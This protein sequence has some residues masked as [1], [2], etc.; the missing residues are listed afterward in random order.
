MTSV[1]KTPEE[2]IKIAK[3]LGE[4]VGISLIPDPYSQV[5]M[6][7]THFITSN[8]RC[9]MC[10]YEA[11]KAERDAKNGTSVQRGTKTE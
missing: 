9:P 2:Y 3:V 4:H 10:L 1:K 6:M 11:A 8:P 7:A 5:I